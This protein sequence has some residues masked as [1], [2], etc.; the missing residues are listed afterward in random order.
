MRRP[1]LQDRV[2]HA[3]FWTDTSGVVDTICQRLHHARYRL[4]R[5]VDCDLQ[6]DHRLRRER[7][8]VESPAEA[9]TDDCGGREPIQ[10]IDGGLVRQ[11]RI[12]GLNIQCAVR[13]A[14]EVQVSR[15]RQDALQRLEQSCS[16]R[17]RCDSGGARGIAISGGSVGAANGSWPPE[18]APRKSATASAAAL[19]SLSI[20]SLALLAELRRPVAPP[21]S[22]RAPHCPALG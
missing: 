22:L 3:G 13:G 15:I 17:L 10:C 11:Q 1:Y 20:I 6:H 14:G 2:A 8:R 12:L 4:R 7:G 21:L 19:M 5:I 9:G 16:G 18:H